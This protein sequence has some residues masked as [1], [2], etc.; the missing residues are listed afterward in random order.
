VTSIPR[1]GLLWVLPPRSVDFSLFGQ[2]GAHV[3]LERS[4]EMGGILGLA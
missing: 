4:R 1:S 3:T 2:M